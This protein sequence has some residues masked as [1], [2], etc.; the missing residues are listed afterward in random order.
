MISYTTHNYY[1]CKYLQ[2]RTAVICA[3]DFPFWAQKATQEIKRYTGN[4]VDEI[5]AIPDEVQMCCCEVAEYLY[6]QKNSGHDE[7]IS[8]EKVGEFSVSYVSGQTAE[9][10]KRSTIKGIIYNWLAMTG[11]LY[12]G[13]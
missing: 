13:C 7:N 2:G 3:A 11:L 4:N 5:A 1:T 10:I 12:R 8:S 6:K 9:D